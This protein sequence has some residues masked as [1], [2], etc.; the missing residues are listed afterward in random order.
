[1]MARS[2]A[3]AESNEAVPS[4]GARSKDAASMIAAHRWASA[5]CPVIAVTQPARTASGGYSPIAKSPSSESHRCT[6][7]IWPA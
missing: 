1:M 6:V 4:V 7:V 5:V 3:R 2:M